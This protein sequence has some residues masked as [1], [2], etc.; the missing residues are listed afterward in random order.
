M[1]K[2]FF[3]LV[4]I[5]LFIACDSNDDSSES[6]EN[7]GNSGNPTE[8][9]SP[10]RMTF[11]GKVYDLNHAYIV[12]ENIETEEESDLAY[13]FSNT[14]IINS[15]Q[16][17]SITFIYMDYKGIRPEVGTIN[18]LLDYSIQIDASNEEGVVTGGNYIVD[19]SAENQDLQTL[20]QEL[21]VRSL[22]TI[23]DLEFTFDRRDGKEIKGFYKGSFTT[24]P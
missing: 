6:P 24:I 1:K 13:I 3:T 12:D 23:V 21:I 9:T 16:K 15:N 20:Q 11:D 17:D 4:A 18:N 5:S 7:P 22:D 8:V 14:D 2:T 10:G 19:S